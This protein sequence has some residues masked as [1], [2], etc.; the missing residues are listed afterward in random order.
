MEIVAA[1]DSGRHAFEIVIVDD[2]STDGT[3]ARLRDIAGR[4]PRLRPLRH[5]ANAGQSRALATGVTAARAAIVLTL[6]GDLQ[7]DPKDGV[8]L[9]DALHRAPPEVAM[10]AGERSGRRDPWAKRAA[11]SFANGLRRRVLRDGARDTGC[12]LKAFR[13]DAFLALPYF[14]HM[15][16]FLPALM[17]GCGHHVRFL[18]VGHRPRLTGRSKYTNWR[19]LWVSLWDLAGVAWLIRRRRDP[20]AIRP[21]ASDDAV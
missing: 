7:N 14:D 3:D 5:S 13:R 10:V 15:H 4:E 2:A 16:R 6:D 1:F 9:I 11:S 8:T 17:R 20:G 21:I 12:G 18:P 19:R